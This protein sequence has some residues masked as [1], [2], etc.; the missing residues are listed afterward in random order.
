[1]GVSCEG[2]DVVMIFLAGKAFRETTSW[3]GGDR[4][5][6]A[7][8]LYGPWVFSKVIFCMGG[9]AIEHSMIGNDGLTCSG[10]TSCIGGEGMEQEVMG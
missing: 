9:E 2:T 5:L 7:V 6:T 1:M 8:T 10:E 4:I 3:I